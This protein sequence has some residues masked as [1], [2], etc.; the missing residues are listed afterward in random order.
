MK[1]IKSLL[2]SS[3]ETLNIYVCG[4]TVY[5]HV[6]IGNLRPMIIFDVLTSVWKFLGKNINFLLNITDIDDKIIQKAINTKQNEENVAN[7]YFQNYLEVLKIYNISYP[8]KIWKV[9]EKLNE[10][11]DYI[12]LLKKQGFTYENRDGDLMF[13]IDKLPN[14]GTVS[15]QNLSKLLSKE[16]QD[17][18]FVLWKKTKIG[19]TYDSPFGKGR[20]G[21]HTECCAMIWSYFGDSIDIHGGGVDLVFPHHENEN[22]QHYALFSKEITKHW[23]RVGSLTNNGQKMSKSLGNFILAKDFAQ[24]HDPD[25]LRNFFLSSSF[26]SPVDIKD[27]VLENNKKVIKNY[28]ISF[29]NFLTQNLK[30]NDQVVKEILKNFAYLNFSIGN[31]LISK[32]LRQKDHGSLAVVFKKLG[33]K[34]A[35]RSLSEQ[36]KLDYQMWKEFYEKGD[37]ENSDKLR[38]K[39]WKKFIFS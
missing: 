13:S 38:E 35:T 2:D 26:Q 10:I 5:D 1:Q 37:Y 23:L 39:L 30:P 15:G 8:T 17:K 31:S 24:E 34:F 14:Y 18:D 3:K 16:A 12:S 32:A 36:D 27:D 6:H 4:P 25:V 28:K 20:P 19:V 7:F 11:I 29:Y 9:T 22:A 33:F 21:W